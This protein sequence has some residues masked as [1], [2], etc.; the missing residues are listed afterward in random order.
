MTTRE[1]ILNALVAM[2]AK[3]DALP[4]A[5]IDEPE[6]S[7][8]IEAPAAPGGPPAMLHALAVQDDTP[9]TLAFVRGAV[10]D[11]AGEE[12]EFTPV[13]AYA[14]QIKPAAGMSQAEVRVIRRAARDAGVKLIA[15]LL[16]ADRTLG[17]D[18]EVC[19]EIGAPARDDD[20]AF[21]NALPSATA[22]IPVRVLYTG[23]D[24]A[25]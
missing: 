12:L 10:F 18:A 23:R 21:P 25:S 15:D 6:P 1:A 4:P 9:E 24:A 22:L 13:I 7:R 17:L 14:V 3:S 2:L 5:V 8:W 19:A 20:V 11:E 16:K